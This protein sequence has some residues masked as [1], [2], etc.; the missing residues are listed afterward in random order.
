VFKH[1]PAGDTDR[2]GDENKADQG[3]PMWD[4]RAFPDTLG[5]D[6]GK[7]CW[8][9]PGAV[10]LFKQGHS[11]FKSRLTISFVGTFCSP[12]PQKVEISNLVYCKLVPFVKP[13]QLEIIKISVSPSGTE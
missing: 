7:I 9:Q 2:Q 5:D 8:D 1:L 6:A 12:Q 10:V 3:N 11:P 13:Y 4:R